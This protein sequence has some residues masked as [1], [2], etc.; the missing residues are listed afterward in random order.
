[1]TPNQPEKDAPQQLSDHALAAT[2]WLQR[3]RIWQ[4]DDQHPRHL[5][6][7]DE[8]R[9]L[10]DTLPLKPDNAYPP[11][12][13]VYRYASLQR[14]RRRQRQMVNALMSI[15]LLFVL[16]ASLSFV[17]TLQP[18]PE[19]LTSRARLRAAQAESALHA[20]DA[21][22]ARHLAAEAL[23]LANLPEIALTYDMVMRAPGL[24]A[25]YQP[26]DSPI[27]AL[28]ASA[29]RRQI[30]LGY[31]DGTALVWQPERDHVFVRFDAGASVMETYLNE[32][33]AH[34]VVRV[35]D[36]TETGHVRAW[37]IETSEAVT[38]PNEIPRTP[39]PFERACALVGVVL[40]EEERFYVG[41]TQGILTRCEALTERVQ[42]RHLVA[43]A[44]ITHLLRM[45]ND[46]L[47]IT[48]GERLL[49]WDE[50]HGLQL[51]TSEDAELSL[52]TSDANAIPEELNNALPDYLSAWT[53]HPNGLWFATASADHTL[54]LWSI[55]EA[56]EL[57]R[58]YRPEG[59]IITR[60]GY[61]AN[62]EILHAQTASGVRSAWNLQPLDIDATRQWARDNRLFSQPE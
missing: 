38:P 15:S 39:S 42:A 37:N 53:R 47:L 62:G 58:I 17:Q 33:R 5:L 35:D 55:R 26:H 29:N 27:T 14:L 56:R 28:H 61:D 52:S 43:D 20:D 1:M 23:A 6:N 11:L 60:L 19:D 34:L 40:R 13:I 48:A 8:L 57:R 49:R 54:R 24:R 22:R 7:A 16:L 9:E 10:D 21:H 45:P 30:A 44:A 51:T 41:S 32:E 46:D 59:D 2:A 25:A 18:P 4:D 3:A 31:A 50:Q 12:A 36:G